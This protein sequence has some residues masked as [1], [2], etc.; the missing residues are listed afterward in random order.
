MEQTYL[1]GTIRERIREQLALKDMKQAQLA[2][3]I[4]IGESTFSRFLSGETAKLDHEYVIRIAREFKVST[5]FLLGVTNVPDR[6]NYDIEEL[7][8]S[9]MA[10]RNLF[11]QRVD[12]RVVSYLLES[13][14][15]ATTAALIAE[16]LEGTLAA[17]IAMQNEMIEGVAEYLSSKGQ[18][19]AARDVRL[20]KHPLYKED[21]DKIQST[22][23][24]AVKEMKEDVHLEVAAKKY[25]REQF[26]T[27]MQNLQK[28]M[29]K[30]NPSITPEDFSGAVIAGISKNEMFSPATMQKLHD[31]MTSIAEDLKQDDENAR[32]DQ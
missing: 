11:T 23:L 19:T 12:P 8:L 28:G 24:A 6:K 4:G 1:S 22:F 13:P 5:D 9:P 16:Y 10:A 3:I 30:P 20:K 15:F 26:E 25:T 21:L 32:H 27:I 29:E 7:G 31:V 17:G 18:K 14:K 2:R